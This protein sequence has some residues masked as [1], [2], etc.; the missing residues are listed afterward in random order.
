MNTLHS[1][2]FAVI[3][4]TAAACGFKPTIVPLPNGE[5]QLEDF[6]TGSDTGSPSME[7]AAAMGVTLT[8]TDGEITLQ[9]NEE[10]IVTS[11]IEQL[12][13]EDGYVG[14]RMQ[15]TSDLSDTYRINEDFELDG[16]SFASSVIYRSCSGGPINI[17]PRDGSDEF[18]PIDCDGGPCLE[19]YEATTE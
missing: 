18:K 16:V 12:P 9:Q 11:A 14:C 2:L 13:E 1:S 8:V 7:E 19:F 6:I 3:T 15:F 4:L 5:Y 17:T 10:V